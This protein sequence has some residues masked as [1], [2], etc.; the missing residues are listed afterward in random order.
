MVVTIAPGVYMIRKR[1]FAA[2]VMSAVAVFATT[3]SIPAVGAEGLAGLSGNQGADDFDAIAESL[4]I[5]VAE[6][7]SQYEVALST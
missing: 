3:A 2:F 1:W 6:A 4:G 5:S 7:R